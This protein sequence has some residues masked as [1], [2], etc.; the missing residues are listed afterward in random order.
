MTGKAVRLLQLPVVNY[1]G[2]PLQIVRTQ[3]NDANS[4]II[5]A[6]IFDD[7]GYVNLDGYTV[8]LA[9]IVDGEKKIYGDINNQDNYTV[10]I[11]YKEGS[12]DEIDI[13]Y[14]RVLIPAEVM[15]EVGS[16]ESQ[17]CFTKTDGTK[18][19]TQSFYILV[20]EC[21]T[22]G[23]I[24]DDKNYDIL[25]KIIMNEEERIDAEKNRVTAEAERETAEA[26]RKQNEKTRVDAETKRNT[27]EKIRQDN[28]LVRVNAEAQRI[29]DEAV[30]TT[31]EQKR[32]IAESDRVA[33]EDTRQANEIKRTEAEI[34]RIED[35][36]VR[37]DNEATRVS[38]EQGRV[39]AETDREKL[40]QIRQTKETE[41]QTAEMNRVQEESKRVATFD[42]MNRQYAENISK[43]EK[44]TQPIDNKLAGGVGVPSLEIDPVTGG[45]L[46]KNLKGEPGDGSSIIIKGQT[47]KRVYF[48]SDPQEQIN[49]IYPA[50]NNKLALKV[51][52]ADVVDEINVNV[53]TDNRSDLVASQKLASWVHE[54]AIFRENDLKELINS[55][56]TQIQQAIKSIPKNLSQLTADSTHR[57]V[58]DAQITKWDNKSN[59]DGNYNS[60]SNKPTIPTNASFTLKGLGEKSYNNLTD[61]PTIPSIKVNNVAQTTLSFTSDPQAQITAN[62]N[63]IARIETTTNKFKGVYLGKGATLLDLERYQDTNNGEF[64][65]YGYEAVDSPTPNAGYYSIYTLYYANNWVG[66]LYFDNAGGTMWTNYYNGVK[67]QWGGW[68]HLPEIVQSYNSSDGSVRWRKWNDGL[69]EYWANLKEGSGVHN[70]VGISFSNTNYH[71]SFGGYMTKYVNQTCYTHKILIMDKTASSFKFYDQ[72]G[73]GLN[74][75]VYLTG[76]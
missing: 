1:G 28:E 43:V 45:L 16:V 21:P 38:A 51:N 34:K 2:S 66:L 17:L 14:A 5:K 53:P 6:V 60:L 50:I 74:R 49:E 35:E 25:S 47:A 73:S 15:L 65:Y 29:K 63:A 4:R 75:C 57:V 23:I 41:R 71:V 69:I 64:R 19:T 42:T 24:G 46:V 59:F 20:D 48:T 70:M 68:R 54:N 44:L 52:T 37:T 39:T 56:K 22:G 72:W 12:Q 36:V 8:T 7:A 40:E 13:T 18:L 76:Y 27:Q 55:N 67:K 61:K 62:H 9:C 31:T 26:T 10:E 3:Q 58:T 30:R 11:I 32:T 33:R